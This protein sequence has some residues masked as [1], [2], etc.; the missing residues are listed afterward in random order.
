VGQ[1]GALSRGGPVHSADENDGLAMSPAPPAYHASATR[2]TRRCRP[3]RQRELQARHRCGR[4]DQAP[5]H[6]SGGSSSSISQGHSNACI[7]CSMHQYSSQSRHGFH[8]VIITSINLTA[9]RSPRC[10]IS[11]PGRRI[12]LGVPPSRRPTASPGRAS[13]RST[14]RPAPSTW[15]FRIPDSHRAPG[16]AS[17]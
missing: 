9:A 14:F 16:G 2:E 15:S 13:N 10:R 17:R 6:S 7:A 1:A 11:S 8:L 12:A 5:G 3:G 4:T